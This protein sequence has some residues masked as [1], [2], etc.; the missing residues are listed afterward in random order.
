[1]L[2]SP[3]GDSEG[4]IEAVED[5]LEGRRLGDDGVPR[6]GRAVLITKLGTLA[7]HGA[8]EAFAVLATF[9]DARAFSRLAREDA[10][11]A[12]GRVDSEIERDW[13]R[14]GGYE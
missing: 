13:E 10:H 6:G 5:H 7:R 1:M 3:A 8:W 12:V 9:D 11:Q 2:T 4:R 14:G